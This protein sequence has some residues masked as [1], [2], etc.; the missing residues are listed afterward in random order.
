MKVSKAFVRYHLITPPN[1]HFFIY[2]GGVCVKTVVVS[3][4]GEEREVDSCDCDVAFTETNLFA[5]PSCEYNA[6][7]VCATPNGDGIEG[8]HFCT[9]GGTCKENYL[10]GCDCPPAW[11][12]FRCQFATGETDLPEND[13]D[14]D[15]DG[16]TLKNTCELP[17]KNGGVCAEGA[18]DLGDLDSVIGEIEH[19]NATFDQTHFAHCVCPEGWVGLTCDH[20]IEVCGENEHYCLHGSKCVQ[21]ETGKHKC[22]CAEADEVIGDGG[23]PVFAGDYCEH[24][25]TDICTFGEDYPGKPIYFCV[26]SGRCNAQVSSDQPDPGCSCGEDWTG[27]HCETRVS[28][29]SSVSSEE[30]ASNVGLIIGSVIGVLLAILAVMFVSNRVQTKKKST[31]GIGSASGTPFPLRRRRIHG[32]GGSPNLA[33]TSSRPTNGTVSSSSDPVVA[34]FVLT[35]E[36]EPGSY[37]ENDGV[38]YDGMTRAESFSEEAVL[39]APPLDEDGNIIDSADRLHSV[40]FV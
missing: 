31:T 4:D 8:F 1:N 38:M 15:S 29:S 3:P 28:S 17:C 40:D 11:H 26:N 7:S 27:P 18:K 12:G 5:G 13:S 32:Y 16:G 9:N 14:N 6:T 20:K 2:Q 10:E 21:D 19:L 23:V 39:V 22:D 37:D 25:A 36:D 33:S 24:V 35:P 30:S 34:G